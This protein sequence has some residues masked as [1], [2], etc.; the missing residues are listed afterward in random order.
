MP[1]VQ[2]SLQRNSQHIPQKPA[3]PKSSPSLPNSPSLQL[4]Y[5]LSKPTFQHLLNIP[6][7]P[8]R[9]LVLEHACQAHE[10]L[11]FPIRQC[12]RAFFR[13]INESRPIP[14]L[15]REAVSQPWHK[16]F[17]LVQIDLLKTG[18]PNKLSGPARKDLHGERGKMYEVLNQ[19]LRCLADILGERRDGRG[20]TTVLDVLRSVKA[21]VWE[22]NG[23]DLMQVPDIG[24][25]RMEKL[26]Q[27]GVRN[28]RQ[29]AN[30]EFYHIERILSRNP[31][32]GQTILR[33]VRD[34]PYL[35]LKID[36]LQQQSHLRQSQV[37]PDVEGRKPW[38]VR[39]WLGL[40]NKDLPT[41]H[42]VHPWT[43]FQIDREDGQLACFWRGSVK[44]LHGGKVLTEQLIAHEGEEMRVTFAC[45]EIVGTMVRETFKI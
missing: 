37:G 36:I 21:S 7:Q 41:W 25:G 34:F 33:N 18:W 22:G 10:F 42:K 11:S 16:V 23:A 15:V 1:H 12:E 43:T 28:I 5:K 35:Q 27:A 20:L 32:F 26:S 4:R 29:L 2:H 38:V 17:L 8:D 40:D 19:V 30:M 31:P 14:Y 9:R 39:I 6:H 3:N 44:R 13:D 45:E 24:L